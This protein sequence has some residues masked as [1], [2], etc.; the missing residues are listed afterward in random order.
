MIIIDSHVHLGQDNVFDYELT[1]EQ[2]LSSM[3]RNGVSM[4]IVQPLIPRPYMSEHQAIHDRIHAMAVKNPGRIVGMASINPH[5]YRDEYRIELFRCVRELRFIGVK[6][7]PIGHAANPASKDCMMVYEAAGE[8]G[9]PV[10][11]HTGAGLPFADPV[12]CFAAARRFPE[13]PFILA[14]AGSDLMFEQALMLACECVNVYLEPSWV[15]ILSVRA[16]IGALGAGRVMFS[17]DDPA[18]IPVELAKYR[19]LAAGTKELDLL[20]GGTA[21]KVFKLFSSNDTQNI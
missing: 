12:A 9:I 17:S 21:I 1:E 11:I 20:L 10:M 3:D 6:I 8:L 5:F 15:N 18:N 13:V 19:E 2:V 7:T 14:H 16:A 4:S